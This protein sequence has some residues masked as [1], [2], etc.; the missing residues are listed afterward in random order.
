MHRHSP[1][2]R[3]QTAVLMSADEIEHIMNI[4]YA[5]VHSGAPYV[6][7]YYYQA[8]VN[9]HLNGKNSPIFYPEVS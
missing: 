4:M 2:R 8:F 9:R 5:A 6:E 7:D 3:R 1:M